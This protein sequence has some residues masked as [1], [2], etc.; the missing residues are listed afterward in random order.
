LLRRQGPAALGRMAVHQGRRSVARRFSRHEFQRLRPRGPELLG[1]TT[2]EEQAWLFW[3]ASREY[4]GEGELVDL[5]CWLGSSTIAMARGLAANP[6]VG[7]RRGRIHAYDL[8]RWEEWMEDSV[9]GTP[10]SG[11][12][13]AGASFLPEFESRISP[14]RQAVVTHPG[15]LV[16]QGW[17][18]ARPIDLLFNDASKSFDLANAVVRDFWPALVPGRSLVVEQDFVHFYT[19]WVHL[20]HERVRDCFEPVIHIPWSGSMV[21]RLAR[22]LPAERISRPFAFDDFTAEEIERAFETSLGWVDRPMR[23]NVWAARVMLEVHRGR[24]DAARSLFAE[25]RRRGFRGLDLEKVRPLLA[26]R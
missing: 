11:R 26:G 15:D 1:M 8:F 17:G 5:G 16:V 2:P 9:A 14:W 4:A 20:I 7:D 19:P 13:A 24:L 21:F 23:P 12:L 18:P 25:G 3:Y 10:L 22:P 6:R